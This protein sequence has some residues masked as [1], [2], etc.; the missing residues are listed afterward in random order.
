MFK[1]Q[2]VVEIYQS[3]VTDCEIVRA[4]VFQECVNIFPFQIN[5]FLLEAK[6]I[7]YCVCNTTKEWRQVAYNIFSD[8]VNATGVAVR[9][10]CC[11]EL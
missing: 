7:K 3:D 5:D 8:A 9:A 4:F 11:E 1:M 10:V 2:K 6:Y